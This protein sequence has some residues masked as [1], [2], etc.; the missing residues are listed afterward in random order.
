MTVDELRNSY[1]VGGTGLSQT[2]DSKWRSN[3][4]DHL[5]MVVGELWQV[6]VTEIFIDGSFVEDKDHPHDID[7]YFLCDEADFISGALERRLN[8]ISARKIWTWDPA[9]RRYS[10]S[11]GRWQLPMW[12]DHR[13]DMYPHYGQV[14]GVR[15]AYGHDL[16]FPSLFR[17]TRHTNLP[18]GIVKIL[19]Q[20]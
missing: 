8:A 16:L 15:D 10:P 11:T 6:G 19:P 5:E 7:G 12:H 20:P 9:S 13:V 17:L 3:L 1:L 4:V 18:K 14:S 2:W